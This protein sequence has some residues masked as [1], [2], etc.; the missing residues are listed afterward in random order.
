MSKLSNVFTSIGVNDKWI[1][2]L[3]KE[4]E[5]NMI[6]TLP[7]KELVDLLKGKGLTYGAINKIITWK[8]ENKSPI[9]TLTNL[10]TNIGVNNKWIKLLEEE[11]VDLNII[12]T[13]PE[14]ELVELLEEFGLNN[15][16]ITKI[17]IWKINSLWLSHYTQYQM[18]W[19]RWLVN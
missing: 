6:K 1:K 19:M 18:T 8:K 5:L 15:E 13:L 4:V 12:N 9:S 10:F 17:I 7:E 2:L 11:D 16:E 14:K 3:E